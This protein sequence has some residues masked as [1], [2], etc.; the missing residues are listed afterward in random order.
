MCQKGDETL[1]YNVGSVLD[2]I[3]RSVEELERME[4]LPS[5]EDSADLAPEPESPS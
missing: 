1:Q 4:S 5:E 3:M 2:D